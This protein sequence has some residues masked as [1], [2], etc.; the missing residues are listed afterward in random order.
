MKRRKNQGA[1]YVIHDKQAADGKE[2][3]MR[4]ASPMQQKFSPQ[5]QSKQG[6]TQVH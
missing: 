1:I 3:K 5:E 2:P 6:T 4:I